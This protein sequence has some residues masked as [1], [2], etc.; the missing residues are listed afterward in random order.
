MIPFGGVLPDASR[1]GEDGERW[2]LQ[3]VPEVIQELP[4]LRVALA[5]REPESTHRELLGG[6]GF[7]RVVGGSAGASAPAPMPE[8]PPPALALA[9]VTPDERQLDLFAWKPRPRVPVQGNLFGD[10][11]E[12]KL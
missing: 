5:H 3:L 8:A 11:E 10:P 12:V 1:P 2:G 9:P 6:R 7:L 4:R